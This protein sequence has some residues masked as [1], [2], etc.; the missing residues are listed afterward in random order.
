M[1]KS[2]SQETE[3]QKSDSSEKMSTE[4]FWKLTD[5]L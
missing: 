4:E 1:D 2:L 3:T 5:E